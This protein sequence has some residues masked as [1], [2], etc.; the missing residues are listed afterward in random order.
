MSS[1][2]T[3]LQILNVLSAGRPI[4]RVGEVCRELGIPK[5]SVSRLM[6]TLSDFGLLERD[7]QNQG[8]VAG[9]QVLLMA[10]LSSVG[11]A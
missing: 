1:L 11:T 9:P 7:P 6:R 3:G 8:Y 2:E 10:N 4:L 5:S